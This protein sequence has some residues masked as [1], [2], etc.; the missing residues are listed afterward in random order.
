MQDYLDINLIH[1]IQ[2]NHLKAFNLN[3]WSMLTTHKQSHA[4]IDLPLD[5]DVQKWLRN[6]IQPNQVYPDNT[7][8]TEYSYVLVFCDNIPKNFRQVIHQ[9]ILEQIPFSYSIGERSEHFRYVGQIYSYLT[10]VPDRFK[11]YPYQIL[12]MLHEQTLAALH[13]KATTA[14]AMQMP[15]R[16]TPDDKPVLNKL[17][18]DLLIDL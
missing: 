16:F 3:M 6:I 4:S 13:H 5:P 7:M 11:I 17:K 8:I 18:L 2:R 12:E 9:L 15:F 1:T 14:Y 10:V